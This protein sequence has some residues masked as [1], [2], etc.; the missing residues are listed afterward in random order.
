MNEKG[1][2][3]NSIV[4]KISEYW[5]PNCPLNLTSYFVVWGKQAK[6]QAKPRCFDKKDQNQIS[7]HFFAFPGMVYVWAW[8]V[9]VCVCV[10][11][12]ERERERCWIMQ[13]LM[14]A[15]LSNWSSWQHVKS[16]LTNQPLYKLAL[17]SKWSSLVCNPKII[18]LV[19]LKS[20]M[21]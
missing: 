10:C 21:P 3:L 6:R 7:I 14:K 18:F 12:R 8:S 16:V 13:T 4:S 20:K 1:A 19:L 15:N 9:C 11:E 5:F 17:L 2:I